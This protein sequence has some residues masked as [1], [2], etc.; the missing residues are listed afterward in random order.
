MHFGTVPLLPVSD[1]ET[2]SLST[3]ENNLEEQ[4]EMALLN[5]LHRPLVLVFVGGGEEGRRLAEEYR[6]VFVE[7]P[8][9]LTAALFND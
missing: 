5:D 3:E 1:L 2:Y 7:D 9:K 8:T 4:V 6:G